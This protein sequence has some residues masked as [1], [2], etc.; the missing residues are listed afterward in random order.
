MYAELLA[1]HGQ[2]AVTAV[3]QEH[4]GGHR[5]AEQRTALGLGQPQGV[6]IAVE[7]DRAVSQLG[8]KDVLLVQLLSSL[9]QDLG[10]QIGKAADPAGVEISLLLQGR[11]G[12]QAAFR[13]RGVGSRS[14]LRG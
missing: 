1:G 2:H 6:G 8:Q 5:A 14:Y 12:G 11:R 9:L 10:L 13:R 7:F 4:G 3:L